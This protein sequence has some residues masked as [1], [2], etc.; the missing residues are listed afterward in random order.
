[1]SRKRGVRTPDTAPRLTTAQA[2]A[3]LHD[4]CAMRVMLGARP[5]AAS[6]LDLIFYVARF[7]SGLVKVGVA[8]SV[9]NR[10]SSLPFE[11]SRRFPGHDFSHDV[12]TPVV[13]VEENARPLE[14][15]VLRE[16]RCERVQGEWFRGPLSDAV[17]R[18]LTLAAQSLERAA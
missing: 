2:L 7:S 13:A 17:V 11:A 15:G 16:L 18:A 3:A 4:G 5:K 14:I 10:L 1:M 8:D 6:Q 9:R 12:I